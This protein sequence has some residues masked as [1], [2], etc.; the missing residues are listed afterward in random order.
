MI[1]IRG[2]KMKNLILLMIIF[3]SGCAIHNIEQTKYDEKGN[4]TD[5]TK[6]WS[7]SFIADMSKSN[8]SGTADANG[9]SVSFG[10]TI[11]HYDPNNVKNVST[12]GSGIILG[13][14]K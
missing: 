6:Y 9:I 5:K 14:L 4:V 8:A 3:I 10:Q 1:Y 2:N 11:I 7:G 12:A 13:V